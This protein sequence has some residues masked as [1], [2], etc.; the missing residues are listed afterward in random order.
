MAKRSY[1]NQSELLENNL[2]SKI[3]K[4]KLARAIDKD[5]FMI[6]LSRGS[7]VMTRKA[8]TQS[9]VKSS[10]AGSVDQRLP[11]GQFLNNQ[12]F[13][14]IAFIMETIIIQG[15]RAFPAGNFMGMALSIFF[16]FLNS[17]LTSHP[18]D[19][20]K[21]LA[22]ITGKM[23]DENN[24]KIIILQTQGIHNFYQDF[25]RT[26]EQ[27]LNKRQSDLRNQV[28]MKFENVIS[29]AKA[30]LPTLLNLNE[31][32]GL[33][34]YCQ[35]AALII[36]SYKDILLNSKELSLDDDYYRANLKNMR[37][38][39]EA[40]LGLAQSSILQKREDL[41]SFDDVSQ[42]YRMMYGSGYSALLVAFKVS[43]SVEFEIEL[44]IKNSAELYTHC[45]SNNYDWN[46]VINKIKK[47][48]K[49]RTSL[50]Y[51]ITA[52]GHSDAVNRINQYYFDGNG[53]TQGVT[54]ETCSGRV[55]DGRENGFD[56]DFK[57][58]PFKNN[59]IDGGEMPNTYIANAPRK[60]LILLI[61]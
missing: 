23:I 56:T 35:A 18:E 13:L 37:E 39:A 45:Y 49:K 57:I 17:K 19:M 59:D 32:A 43:Y 41:W 25:Q 46:Q 6:P 50:P 42:H 1:L 24:F 8:L 3:K 27:Y 21:E 10:I 4:T 2:P 52:H 33:P 47:D 29:V 38:D 28:L 44:N 26:L 53:E 12:V 5:N 51:A 15:V 11:L 9:I 14:G 61:Y 7:N 58:N 48:S 40:M 20:R 30:N 55:G 34:L 36:Q 31:Q 60:V 54:Y 22:A 16:G